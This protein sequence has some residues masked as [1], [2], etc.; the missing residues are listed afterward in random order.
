[1]EDD[2][3]Q[4]ED[5]GFHLHDVDEQSLMYGKSNFLFLEVLN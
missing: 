4:V 1:V 2:G 3:F 5:D